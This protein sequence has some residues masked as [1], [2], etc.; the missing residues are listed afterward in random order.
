M[1]L[2]GREFTEATIAQIGGIIS[3]NPSMSRR[4]VSLRVCEL[5]EW[6][7][8]NGKLKDVSCRKALLELHRRGVINLPA[9]EECSFDRSNSKHSIHLVAPVAEVD[10]SLKEL[11]TIRIVP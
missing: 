9:A 2:C 1:R 8:P 7:A 11:G 6:R 5:L 3:S 10:C 4:A